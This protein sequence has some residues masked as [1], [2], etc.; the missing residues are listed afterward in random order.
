MTRLFFS[1]TEAHDQVGKRV[2]A[3]GDIPSI[4]VGT[5]GNVNRTRQE[6]MDGWLVCVEWDLPQKISSYFA[7]IGD[8]SINI[9]RRE[10]RSAAEFSKDEFERFV[11]CV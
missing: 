1:R 5:T 11:Q 9:P 8:L 2:K 3:L 6:G 10:K 7:M 4:P